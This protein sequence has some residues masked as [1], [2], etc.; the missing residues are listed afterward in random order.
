L[1]RLTGVEA[2]SLPV[3]WDADFVLGPRD[4]N[5]ADTYVL[6]EI[7]VSAVAPFPEQAVPKLA[8]AVARRLDPTN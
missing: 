1:Q 2:G 5:G 8:Q 7:N 4:R 6:T 3:L